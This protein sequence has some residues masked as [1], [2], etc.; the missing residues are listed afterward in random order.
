TGEAPASLLVMSNGLLHLPSRTLHPHDPKLFTTMGV[1]YAFMP[2]VAAPVEWKR[3]LASIWGD[4]A[5]SIETLQE[6]FGYCLTTDCS[7]QKIPLIVGPKRSGKGTI[8][9]V[10][11]SLIGEANC[12]GPTLASLAA[13]FGLETLIGKRVAIFSDVRLSG[14]I[15][16]KHLADR[17]LSISGEDTLSIDR[18][19]KAAWT[20][21]L[22]A[23][24]LMFSNELPKIL[25]DSGALASRFI[26]LRMRKSFYGKEDLGLADRLLKELPAILNWSLDGL[27]RLKARGAFRQ[28]QSALEMVRE[29]EKL[30]S[31]IGAFIEDKCVTGPNTQVG[32]D[33]LYQVY[34]L[35][36]RIFEGWKST[37]TK[38]SF[39]ASLRA[40]LPELERKQKGPRGNQQWFY[41]GVGLA[42]DT[43]EAADLSENRAEIAD[44]EAA[45]AKKREMLL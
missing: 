20:C 19:Y 13:P 31:P 29:L 28:P 7:Q 36:C 27:E 22:K 30:S 37:P 4:D 17:L 1:P 10:L 25:D 24:L 39:G 32:C 8:A 21:A 11:R 35:Y 14:H 40:A 6:L 38:T 26:V 41:V 16:Q 42:V 45:R 12:V 2:D 9:R 44:L 34:N 33:Q 5:E 18:K 3:F 15:D 43:A 23:R